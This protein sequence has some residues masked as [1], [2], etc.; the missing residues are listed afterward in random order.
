MEGSEIAGSG[1]LPS[2]GSEAEFRSRY[3]A[4]INDDVDQVISSNQT[5]FFRYTKSPAHY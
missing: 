1:Y 4:M 2:L 5:A 3:V